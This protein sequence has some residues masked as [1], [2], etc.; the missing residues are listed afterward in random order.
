MGHELRAQPHRAGGST[1]RGSGVLDRDGGLALALS[2]NH[3]WTGSRYVDVTRP[4]PEDISISEIATGLSR[5]SRYGG[6][7]TGIFWS[8]A[9]HTLLCYYLAVEDGVDERDTLGLILFHDA[10]EYM[11]RDLIR[12][13]KANCPS[14]QALE[15]AWWDAVSAAFG[16]PKSLTPEVKHY[17]NLALAVEKEALVS[18]NAGEWPGLPDSA[19][20]SI[21]GW[22][23]H[24]PM[25]DAAAHLKSAMCNYV[26][27]KYRAAEQA[28]NMQ[29]AEG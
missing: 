22:L 10:P 27:S 13:V 7:A 17:D 11:L 1:D 25:R 21:P 24:L 12:P 3:A 19:G 29:N 2:P 6:A 8:V 23:L 26:L 15:A 20:R 14:Y 16:L 5:E 4:R 28:H 9:Q 18:R